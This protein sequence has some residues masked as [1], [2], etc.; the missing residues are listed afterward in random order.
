LVFRVSEHVTSTGA[1]VRSVIAAVTFEASGKPLILS[2]WQLINRLNELLDRR[3]FR[4]D[5]APVPS[6]PVADNEEKIRQAEA[7]VRGNLQ[8]LDVPFVVPEVH[9][10][11]VLSPSLIDS[12]SEPA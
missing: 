3:T 1:T 4:R 5:P 2:D 10:V 9:L 6:S 12:P 7:A 11:A 8:G